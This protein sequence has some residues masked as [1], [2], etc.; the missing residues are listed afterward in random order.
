[1][2]PHTVPT[3]VAKATATTEISAELATPAATRENT[4]RPNW[5]V[6]NQCT[7]DG[8]CRREG[9]SCASG[10]NGSSPN[11]ETRLSTARSAT[12]MSPV[13]PLRL[14]SRRRTRSM[15]RLPPGARAGV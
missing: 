11:A 12:M 5:S 15:A 1:M 6:P 2:S 4:S 3:T 9:G 14:R 7:A 8:G 13:S 10:S